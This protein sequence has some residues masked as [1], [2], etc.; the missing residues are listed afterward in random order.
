MLEVLDL[1]HNP[2]VSSIFHW[3]QT[4][5]ALKK[6]VGDLVNLGYTSLLLSVTGVLGSMFGPT[7]IMCGKR[8]KQLSELPP[9]VKRTLGRLP[10]LI[11]EANSERPD[12]IRRGWFSPAMLDGRT[13]ERDP[14]G[15]RYVT[16]AV[17]D[18]WSPRARG[19]DGEWDRAIV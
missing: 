2:P 5:Y 19:L 11:A 4:E 12:A 17:F 1:R 7:S 18:S 13:P 9:V 3:S 15:P 14:E 6:V 8:P 10:M 16:C